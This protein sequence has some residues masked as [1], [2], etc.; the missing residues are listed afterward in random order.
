[1]YARTEQV[2]RY[3]HGSETMTGNYGKTG[4]PTDQPT[5]G[6]TSDN[7][8]IQERNRYIS[9]ISMYDFLHLF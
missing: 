6:Q 3:E 9:N 1:M 2:Q 4:Q 5:D 8:L 7:V